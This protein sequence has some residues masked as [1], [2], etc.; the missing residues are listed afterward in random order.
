MDFNKFLQIVV[1]DVQ[2]RFGDRIGILYMIAAPLVLTMIIGAAFSNLSGGG[3]DVPIQNIKVGIVNEDKGAAIFIQQLNYGDILTSILVPEGDRDP[4]NTL[5]KLINAREMTRDE[6]ISMVQKGELTAAVIIPADFST[7]LNPMNPELA[8]TKITLYRDSGSPISSSI[9]SSVVRGIVNNLVG[10]NIAV[11]ALRDQINAGKANPILM[12]QAQDIA[13][14]YGEQAQQNAPISIREMSIDGQSTEQNINPL[15][16]FAASMAIFFMSFTMASGATSI[17][18]EQR[19]WT[20]QRLISSPTSAVTILAGKLGSTFIT[21]VLQ[22]TILILA[23]AILAPMLGSKSSVWGTN[24][25]GIALM[26][27]SAVAAA[28]G[29]GTLI[30]GVSKNTQQAETYSNAVLTLLGL[31]GGT[32]FTVDALGGPFS[33]LTRFT[34]NHW[35]VNGFSTLANTNDLSLVLPNIGVLLL[36]FAVFFSVGVF[37]FNRRLKG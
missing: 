4:N 24:I 31:L 9:V 8:Q 28:T 25:P 2:I 30:A 29:L 27:V 15:Q 18:E 17:I 36:M 32:F 21:G 22:L 19:D 10:G 16:Y 37:L 35:S 1:K 11:V 26:V 33:I 20:L 34:L 5:H 12:S 3:G 7:S 13:T 23:T 14:R 6:A